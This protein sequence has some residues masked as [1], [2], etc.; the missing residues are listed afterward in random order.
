LFP[1]ADEGRKL[2]KTRQFMEIYIPTSFSKYTHVVYNMQKVSKRNGY[3]GELPKRKEW[4]NLWAINTDA[5]SWIFD[6]FPFFPF[7]LPYNIAEHLFAGWKQRRFDENW[8]ELWPGLA[9]ILGIPLY[10]VM[11]I[12]VANKENLGPM[13]NGPNTPENLAKNRWLRWDIIRIN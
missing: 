5:T 2:G 8:W 12:R 13:K 9:S 4:Q 1:R 7:S 11:H 6:F 3:E 10:I